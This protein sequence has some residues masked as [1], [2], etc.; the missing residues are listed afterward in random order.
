MELLYQTIKSINKEI[1]E[2]VKKETLLIR[3]DLGGTSDKALKDRIFKILDK[4]A[5]LIQFPIKDE[6]LCGFICKYKGELFVFINTYLPLEKQIFAAG[7]ELYHLIQENNDKNELLKDEELSLNEDIKIKNLED[8][9]A[10]LFSALLLVPSESL[11]NELDLLQVQEAS[12]LTLI[13]I[14]RLMDIFAVP[15]KTIIIRLYE[16]NFINK[17]QA[18]QW[19]KIKDR[20]KNNGV[21]FEIEKHQIGQRWQERTMEVKCSDLKALVLDNQNDELFTKAKIKEF[22]QLLEKASGDSID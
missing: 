12:N 16:I 7:H 3:K 14:I 15:Y 4:K 6:D 1:Y 8:K 18:K 22:M 9:K 13:D 20:D 2:E 11:K 19:L 5:I 10:N 21:L 17:V